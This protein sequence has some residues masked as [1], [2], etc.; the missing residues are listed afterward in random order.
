LSVE[1]ALGWPEKV[2]CQEKKVSP[3]TTKSEEMFLLVEGTRLMLRQN[4]ARQA[5][6]RFEGLVELLNRDTRATQEFRLMDLQRKAICH[7]RLDQRSE[8]FRHYNSAVYLCDPM[9]RDS[10]KDLF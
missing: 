3:L 5:L 2:Y 10:I 1:G 8:E 7:N 9:D 4:E 6:D